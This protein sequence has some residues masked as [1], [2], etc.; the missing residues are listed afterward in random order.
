MITPLCTSWSAESLKVVSASDYSF[1][2]HRETLVRIERTSTVIRS[3][4]QFLGKHR[5]LILEKRCLKGNHKWDGEC[6]Q[7]TNIHAVPHHKK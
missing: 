2:E 7:R 3:R 6:Q 4:R 1:E 5:S